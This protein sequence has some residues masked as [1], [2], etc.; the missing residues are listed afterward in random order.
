MAVEIVSAGEGARSSADQ[1]IGA[2]E[3]HTLIPFGMTGNWRVVVLAKDSE[4][5]YGVVGQL[6]DGMERVRQ[7]Q[8]PLEYR[9]D[10]RNCGLSVETGA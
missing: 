4:G 8:G 1:S 6:P 5:E 7:L 10:V 2:G 3:V 9:A